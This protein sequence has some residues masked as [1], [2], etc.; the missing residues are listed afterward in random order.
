MATRKT[1]RKAT[2]PA[3]EPKPETVVAADP[4]DVDVELDPVAPGG[5]PA[6]AGDDV[7][8]TPETVTQ[9]DVD[10]LR[11]L[12]IDLDAAPG[13]LDEPAEQT[14]ARMEAAE[15]KADELGSRQAVADGTITFDLS[16]ADAAALR[17]DVK[18]GADWPRVICMRMGKP[19]Q[20]VAG[21]HTWGSHGLTTLKFTPFSIS[22]PL[23]PVFVT[24]ITKPRENRRYGTH[25]YDFFVE[26]PVHMVDMRTGA[27]LEPKRRGDCGNTQTFRDSVTGRPIQTC[28][29]GDCP[30]H[31]VPRGLFHSVWQAQRYLAL[32][33]NDSVLQRYVADFDPRPLVGAFAQLVITQRQKKL[34]EDMGVGTAGNPNIVF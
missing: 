22:P 9:A 7:S 10:A 24:S 16:G 5:G 33:K 3:V 28:I 2:E 6:E 31:P 34:L 29:Y 21:L 8:P 26:P 17:A 11:A 13:Y 25:W 14:R 32:L 19:G 20:K 23:H 12:D 18:P 4:D 27:V 30:R 15:K 1:T